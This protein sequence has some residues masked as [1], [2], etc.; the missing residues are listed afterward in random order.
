MNAATWLGRLDGLPSGHHHDRT[1]PAQRPLEWSP[2]PA[3]QARTDGSFTARALP[4]SDLFIDPLGL[5][6]PV[7][8]A[9]LLFTPPGDFTLSARVAVNFRATFDAGVLCLYDHDARW[10]KLCLEYSPAG[11]PMI[12]SA[13]TRGTSDDS[14]A[15]VLAEAS[16]YLRVA[17]LSQAYAFHFSADGRLWQMVRLFQLDGVVAGPAVRAGFLVQSPRGAGCEVRFSE[18]VYR[19]ERLADVRS[20]V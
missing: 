16:V 14:N 5:A 20:G 18:I 2:A 13:V 4:D 10:A 9:K 11:Q 3:R 12:V 15:V 19:P 1:A 8:A 17:R 6:R 7:N